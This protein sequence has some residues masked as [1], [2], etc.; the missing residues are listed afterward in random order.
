MQGVLALER[1]VLALETGAMLLALTWRRPPHL[2]SARHNRTRRLHSGRGGRALRV[3]KKQSRG[4][5]VLDMRL[6][7]L[8]VRV[9]ALE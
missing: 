4:V 8:D 5:L 6:V 2:R 7:A 9:F 3:E 1:S